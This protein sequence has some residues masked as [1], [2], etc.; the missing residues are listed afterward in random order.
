MVAPTSSE[1]ANSAMAAVEVVRHYQ[2]GKWNGFINLV[3]H[4]EIGNEPDSSFFWPAT[5]TKEEFY[6]LYSDTAKAIRAAFPTLMIGGPAITL[7]G[8]KG[9]TGQQWTRGFLDHVKSSGAPLDFLSWH[10]YTN[11]P[12]DY[13]TGA[14]FYRTELANRGFTSTEQHVTEWHTHVTPTNDVTADAANVETRTLG[15]A[16]AITTTSWINLQLAGIKQAFIYRANDPGVTDHS[17]YGLFS[18]EGLARKPA[19]AFSLWS[20][21]AG[22]TDRIDPSASATVS[23]L[24]A[25]AAQRSD[26]QIA[27]LVA[28]M[29]TA[30]K[31]YTIGFS[32]TRR[33]SDYALSL[34]TVDDSHTLLDVTTPTGTSFDIAANSV[35]LLTLHVR[36]G[37]FSAS[38]TSFGTAAGLL[39]GANLQVAGADIG[40]PGLVYLAA[41]AGNSFYFHDGTAWVPYISGDLPIYSNGALPAVL[42]V[43]VFD[44][45]TNAAGLAGVQL[46][47][48]YGSSAN[49][50]VSATRYKSIYTFTNN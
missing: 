10:T 41:L 44:V 40:N 26:G 32:D 2:E 16:A 48:G 28:N 23:G 8:Y 20:E 24:K 27:V 19:L 25:L 21:F 42:S 39:L 31:R 18:T 9:A 34:K 37:S 6:A 15:K 1:L 4:V 47:M 3:T 12:D 36:T 50:M 46:F 5:Y 38:S 35:Q 13:T 7:S 45:A 49:E 29:G 22:Y 14:T 33:L 11:T 43:P 17:R 30:S